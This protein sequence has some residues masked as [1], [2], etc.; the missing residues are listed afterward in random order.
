MAAPVCGRRERETVIVIPDDVNIQ[1][2]KELSLVADSF[3]NG[4]TV[5]TASDMKE[6]DAK[7][8][9]VVFIGGLPQIPLLKSNASKLRAVRP[10][11]RVRCF[12]V[13]NAE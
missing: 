11:R 4:F 1:T 9:N 3:G 6:A 2:L 13:S 7:G 12:F 10:Q 8:R 5:K